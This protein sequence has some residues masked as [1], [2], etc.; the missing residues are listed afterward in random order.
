MWKKWFAAG[1]IIAGLSVGIGA[2]GAHGLQQYVENGKME[3][4]Q[5]LNYETAA[6]YQMFHALA[7]IATA[8]LM[9]SGYNRLLKISAWLISTGI[10]FFCGSLYLLSTRNI[11]GLENWKWL[12]P[13]TPVGGLC[14]IS[15]W[16]LLAWSVF[17]PM[18]TE[19]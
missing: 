16:I 15:G 17:K 8:L 7:L 6:R 5:L 19:A 3:I 10:L 9:R 14:F 2:F 1:A 13:I 18:K 4:K 11:I 12:G